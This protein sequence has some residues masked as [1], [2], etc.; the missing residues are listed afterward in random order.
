MKKCV[1][2]LFLLTIVFLQ[3]CYGGEDKNQIKFI[4]GVAIQDGKA[5]Y[6]DPDK[7]EDGGLF[8]SEDL[9]KKSKTDILKNSDIIFLEG[10][11]LWTYD[12]KKDD[13]YFRIVE[14]KKEYFYKIVDNQLLI[15]KDKI[16]WE[17]V[18]VKIVNIY[19]NKKTEVEKAPVYMTISLESKYF[20]GEYDLIGTPDS[21]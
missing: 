9:I 3:I 12:S 4:N 16:I 1:S 11:I 17:K 2:I 14:T 15:S 5:L 20:K 6:I 21:E 19:D 13:P 10:G 7:M 8:I 18:T